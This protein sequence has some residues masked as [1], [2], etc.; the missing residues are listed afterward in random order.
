MPENERRHYQRVHFIADVQLQH[1]DN[2][3]SCELLDISLKG[4]LIK[5]P[6]NIEPQL[7]DIYGIDLILGKGAMI[8]MEAKISHTEQGHWG[9]QWHNIDIDCFTHLR[10]LLELNTHN[11]DEIH[12]EISEL[13]EPD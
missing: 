8:G 7:S 4:V 6:A 9:F 11:P 3:W 1:N 13:T 5:S 2:Q 10:R 12:R